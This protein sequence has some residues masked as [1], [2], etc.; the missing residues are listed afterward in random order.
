VEIGKVIVTYFPNEYYSL[1]SSLK[2]NEEILLNLV[3]SD[4]KMV[5]NV[6]QTL[7]NGKEFAIK[8]G[9]IQRKFLTRAPPSIQQDF[10]VQMLVDGMYLELNSKD[11]K[12]L[13]S[14]DIRFLFE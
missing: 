4:E 6:P 13:K 8:L 9:K 14:S 7:M 1:H 2:N 11:S 12:I 5:K 3:K 10:E